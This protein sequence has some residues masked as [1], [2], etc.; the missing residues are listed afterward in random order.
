MLI[1]HKFSAL[2]CVLYYYFFYAKAGM[3]VLFSKMLSKNELPV[4]KIRFVS[5]LEPPSHSFRANC[6]N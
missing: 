2:A 6:E 4:A 3:L 5:P 1:V